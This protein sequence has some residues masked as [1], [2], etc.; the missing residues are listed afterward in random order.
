[1][2]IPRTGT[3]TDLQLFAELGEDAR[4]IP[5]AEDGRVVE[6]GGLGLQNA[7]KMLG[8]EHAFADLGVTPRMAGHDLVPGHDVDPVDVGFG[9]DDLERMPP[10]NAVAVSVAGD[11]LILIH[12]TGIDHAGLERPDR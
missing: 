1:M 9:R 12:E 11:G 6:R 7:Q 8:I 5:V 3:V 4:Q 10:G 2:S